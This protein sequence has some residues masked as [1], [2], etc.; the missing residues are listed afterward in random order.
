[1]KI[2][3][4]I[5]ISEGKLQNRPSI[6]FI[7]QIHT[8]VNKI[9]DGDAFIATNTRDIPKALELGAFVIL[10]ENSVNI[11]DSEIAWVQVPSVQKAMTNI[12]RFKYSQNTQV[13]FLYIDKILYHF[14]NIFKK[15]ES[16]FILL[17]ENKKQNFETLISLQSQNNLTI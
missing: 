3:D 9:S 13:Q 12:L 16:N 5:D 8:H 1:M 17:N 4:L 15:R 14:F 11:V 7:T 2:T 6:S 10:Y